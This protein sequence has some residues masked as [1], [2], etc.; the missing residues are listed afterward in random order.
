MSLAAT[1]TTN[2]VSEII[3]SGE[4][5]LFMHGPTFMANP[6]ACSVAIASIRLLMS[7]PWKEDISRIENQLKNGLAECSNFR[8]VDDVRVLGAIGVI[9]IR[10]P[11]DMKEIQQKFVDNGVWLRPFGKLIYTMPPYI[12][13]NED[14]SR[15]AAVMVKAAGEEKV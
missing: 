14:L 12:I 15:I 11:V 10:N 4:S 13:S 8:Q 2:E 7:S 3:S 9:E 5:D 1:L 6:L